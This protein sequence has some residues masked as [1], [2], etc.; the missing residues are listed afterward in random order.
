MLLPATPAAPNELLAPDE[1]DG[2]APSKA[3]GNPFPF[4]LH[5]LVLVD[6]DRDE[7]RPDTKRRCKYVPKRNNVATKNQVKNRSH[8]QLLSICM[9]TTA[10]A[11]DAAAPTAP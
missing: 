1:G 3:M 5:M 6:R 4:P 11:K 9:G 10:I 2:T 8:P 7:S